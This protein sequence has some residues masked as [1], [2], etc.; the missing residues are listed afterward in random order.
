MKKRLDVSKRLLLF[1]LT[2]MLLSAVIGLPSASAAGVMETVEVNIPNAGFEE[3]LEDTTI[4]GWT[5]LWAPYPQSYYE[6]TTERAY[7]GSHSV[8]FTDTSTA[9]GSILQSAQLPVIPG[10]EYTASAMMYLEDSTVAAT[11]LL[12]FFDKDNKQVGGD[13]L[14]HYRTPKNQWFKA[15]VKGVA[16]DQA[17]YARVFPSLSNF[18]TAVAYY[19][20]FKLTYQREA[21]SLSLQAPAYVVAEQTLTAKVAVSQAS[22]LYAADLVLAYDTSALEVIDVELD[23]AFTNGEQAFLSWQDE[24]GQIRIIVSQLMDHSV[25]GDK[26]VV[27][28]TFRVLKGSDSTTLTIRSGAVLA[29][30]SAVNDADLI[31][32]T[33]DIK[34]RTLIVQE[35]EDLNRDG[36]V[37]LVDLLLISKSV[38]RAITEDIQHYDLNGDGRLDIT[39]VGLIALKV[40]KN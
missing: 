28:V 16:P 7:S 5:P 2:L 33:S 26:G 24:G 8:K 9:Q 11:L 36:V 4:P 39:D 13:S 38:D 6:V 18:F 20:D 22:D 10:V 21:M 40:M 15:E 29:P 27:N 30:Y 32:M 31:R 14:F 23:P 17:V 3:E 19:D 12:R 34:A 35:A 1:T 37:N 25:S